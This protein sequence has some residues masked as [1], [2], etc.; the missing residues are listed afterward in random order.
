M[1]QKTTCSTSD[2]SDLFGVNVIILISQLL[3]IVKLP[4]AVKPFLSNSYSKVWE[5]APGFLF[6]WSIWKILKTWHSMCPGEPLGNGLSTPKPQPDLITG[7]ANENTGLHPIL[8]SLPLD[9]LCRSSLIHMWCSWPSAYLPG[10]HGIYDLE[11]DWR[12]QRNWDRCLLA[13]YSAIGG[14]EDC[15]EMLFCLPL[16]LYKFILF[17]FFTINGH[18]SLECV[19][20]FFLLLRNTAHL[21]PSV[22]AGASWAG[23]LEEK[24]TE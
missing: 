18:A 2:T 15:Q 17:F 6:A 13:N 14:S 24:G 7:Y 10:V 3:P 11:H 5:N 22:I 20:W 4:I 1:V 12:V 21:I 8:S 16:S 23:N 9:E 19:Q